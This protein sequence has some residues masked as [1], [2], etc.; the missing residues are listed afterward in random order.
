MA[1]VLICFIFL[2]ELLLHNQHIKLTRRK[3]I[4][5]LHL[6]LIMHD[7]R[8]KCRAIYNTSWHYELR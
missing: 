2:S 6:D 1:A 5:Q 8:M 7:S 4:G 3:D